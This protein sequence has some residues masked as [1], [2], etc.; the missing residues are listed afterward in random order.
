VVVRSGPFRTAV[1]G[2]LVARPARTT[3]D[4]QSR[5]WLHPDRRVRPVLGDNGLVGKPLQTARQLTSRSSHDSPRRSLL[6]NH[7]RQQRDRHGKADRCRHPEESDYSPL[8]GVNSTPSSGKGLEVG[9][10]PG[11]GNSGLKFA[12]RHL[13]RT[14]RR[15]KGKEG[16]LMSGCQSI[17]S[18]PVSIRITSS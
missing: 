14:R 15:R 13:P 10:H 12:I 5:R 17:P 11:I 4:T 1:N 2:T 3:P 9:G 16:L 6:R 8:R 18:P 7:G